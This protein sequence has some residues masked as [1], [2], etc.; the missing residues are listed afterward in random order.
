MA[1]VNRRLSRSKTHEGGTARRTSGKEDLER[2]ALTALLWEDT[3]YEQGS[4]IAQRLIKAVHSTDPTRVCEIASI[5]RNEYGLRHVPLLMARELCR[6]K[7]KDKIKVSGIIDHVIRR[8]DELSEFV[9][10]YWKD[11]KTPLSAQAKKGLAQAFQK[12]NPYQLAKYNR[13]DKAVKLRDVLFLCHA[14]PKDKEQQKVWEQLIDNA[15]PVPDTWEVA[16]SAGKD[17]KAS[18]ERLITEKKLGG[19]A[20]LR[21]LRNMVKVGVSESLIKQAISQANYKL[22]LPYRFIAAAQVVPRLEK[23]LEPVMLQAV[24]GFPRLPG[25]TLLLV[26]ISASMDWALASRSQMKRTDAAAGL[27]ILARELCDDVEMGVFH[28]NFYN[29]P[30]RRGFALRDAIASFG[31]GGTNLGNAVT[32]FTQQFPKYDRL[33]VFTDEQTHD[34]ISVPTGGKNYLINVASYDRTVDFG[35]WTT[36]SGFSEQLLRYIAIYERDFGE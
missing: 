30:P 20:T 34:R 4:D 23:Y 21:N 33:I 31:S 6:H 25:K 2:I 13:Q 5:S 24:E 19:L 32:Q 3:F 14:K 17:K 7:D 36:I 26:D 27:A 35:G 18:W 12:F 10:I 16:L 29:V 22:I 11:G 1:Q 8:A 9:S 28:T 15:L